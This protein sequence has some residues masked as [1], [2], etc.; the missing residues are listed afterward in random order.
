MAKTLRWL[1]PFLALSGGLVVAACISDDVQLPPR[2]Q[3]RDDAAPATD[4]SLAV[5]AYVQ[6]ITVEGITANGRF[7]VPF[8]QMKIRDAA[9]HVLEGQSDQNGRFSF[10]EILPPYDVLISEQGPG[11]KVLYQ[12]LRSATLV[13]PESAAAPKVETNNTDV[14]FAGANPTIVPAPGEGM[15]IE[16]VQ[17]QLAQASL[18]IQDVPYEKDG[19]AFGGTAT[20]FA[21]HATQTTSGAFDVYAIRRTLVKGSPVA[22]T[23]IGFLGNI[24]LDLTGTSPSFVPLFSTQS[25]VTTTSIKVGSYAAPS[26][27]APAEKQLW[28]TKGPRISIKLAGE[29]STMADFEGSYPRVAGYQTAICGIAEETGTEPA[30]SMACKAGFIDTPSVGC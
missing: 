16:A 12:G 26:G 30:V 27:L 8:A 23:S 19:G 5:D 11:R 17:V 29:R 13:L 9:G 14:L 3:N 15:Q 18:S 25:I 2:P 20:C 4:G 22:W 7:L 6:P 21:E 24:L 1:L 28:L 10:K